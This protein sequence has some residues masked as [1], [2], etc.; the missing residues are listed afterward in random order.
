VDDAAKSLEDELKK[1]NVTLIPAEEIEK[2]KPEIG[3]GKFGKVFKGKYKGLN[4]AI[5]K[6]MFDNL[7]QE[8]LNELIVEIKNLLVAAQES[9]H[10]PTFHGV[11]KG[12]NGKHYHLIF[13]FIEGLPLRNVMKDLSYED[14]IWVMYQICE[15]VNL[16]HKKKL[17]HRDLKPENIMMNMQTKNI[18]LI[19]FGTAKIATKT[20][21]FTSKAVGTTFYMAPDYFDFEEDNDDD[22][23]IQN[24]GKVDVWSL[25]CMISEMLSG[26]F[27]W[28]NV[29]KNEGKIEAMLIKKTPFP[30]PKEINEKFPQFKDIIEKC[31]KPNAKERCTVDDVM[32]FLTPLVKK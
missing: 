4:V 16:L 17:Y 30:I 10:V 20:V 7:N 27:P 31:T 29:T 8:N 14:K 23:P 11:W 19:D 32:T 13:E 26:I 21:T 12:K 5:K 9:N 1:N 2:F 25:G 6:M 18:K 24:T 3:E 22:K 15:I 28:T